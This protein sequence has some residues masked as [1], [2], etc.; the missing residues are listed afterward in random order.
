LPPALGLASSDKQKEE[1]RCLLLGSNEGHME[2]MLC[3][4]GFTGEIT[5][6]DIAEKA[7]ARAKQKT[8]SLGFRNVNYI[9]ADLNTDKFEG[10]FDYI[11]AEGVLH[12]IENIEPCLKMLSSALKPD[13][14]FILVEFEGPVRFQ[15]PDI[16]VRW[17]NAALS[18]LPKELRPFPHTDW[19]LE[20]HMPARPDENNRIYYVPPSETDIIAFDP[21]EAISGP[22][23]KRLIPL[24]F[25][26]VERTGF[27]GTLLS[28]MTGHFDFK[29]ANEDEF[30][31]SWLK[32]LIQI[33]DTLIQNKL[34]EDD[35]VFYVLQNKSVTTV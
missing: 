11:I 1:Y 32:I 3:E 5:A 23:L 2:R 19:E 8:E 33:E 29:R 30:A 14:Y 22:A 24:M 25:E 12:H 16:Q 15:L 20:K 9:V 21:S 31:R 10:N 18:V 7:L 17:I 35:F 34:L 28:Y 6:S 13:G 27:G 4:R 26:V